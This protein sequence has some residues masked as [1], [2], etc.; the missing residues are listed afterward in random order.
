[1]W[2]WGVLCLACGCGRIGFDTVAVD[3]ALR[4]GS[5]GDG[6]GDAAALGPFAV[7]SNVMELNMA[8]TNSE[9]PTVTDDLLEIVFSSTR[10]TGLGGVDL[11]T[12][13]RAAVTDPWNAPTLLAVVNSTN[14]D[15]T[16]EITG[17]GLDLVFA[18]NRPGGAGLYD[19]YLSTRASRAA[20]WGTPVQIAELASTADEFAG[21]LAPDRMTII[22]TSSRPGIGG[23][24]IY[25]AVRGTTTAPWNTP[26]LITELDS[27]ADDSAPWMRGDG[28][29]FSFSSTRTGGP[30]S[31]DVYI[32]TRA[33]TADAWSTPLI[34]TELDDA[35][36]DSDPWFAPDLRTMF[37]SRTA[38]SFRNIFTATR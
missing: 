21:T 11:W 24:D 28:R 7:P 34:V 22:F 6:G 14:D 26:T 37:Y 8:G 9:D 19:L 29:T 16:P 18:S 4:D 13:T 10:P 33:T 23:G 30:G 12:S 3:D 17:D 15:T 38:G 5:V 31:Q 32:T 35:N 2:R 27:T 25:Q 1:M 36:Y 20:A